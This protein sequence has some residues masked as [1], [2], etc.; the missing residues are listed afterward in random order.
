[1]EIWNSKFDDNMYSDFKVKFGEFPE[2]HFMQA[3]YLFEALEV[4]NP[5]L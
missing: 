1:M 2:V 3:I 4:R 5:T